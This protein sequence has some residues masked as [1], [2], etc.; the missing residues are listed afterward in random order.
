MSSCLGSFEKLCRST[1]KSKIK[2]LFSI[3]QPVLGSM[4]YFLCP[5]SDYSNV[6]ITD[7]QFFLYLPSIT[8][9]DLLFL[10]N[11]LTKVRQT[12]CNFHKHEN[13]LGKSLLGTS[14]LPVTE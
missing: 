13:Y 11:F 5:V 3:T 1:E 12:Y 14:E 4:I 10:S 9:T 2:V 6:E 7:L 8:K